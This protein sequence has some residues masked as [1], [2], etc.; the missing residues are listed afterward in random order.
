MQQDATA[1][2]INKINEEI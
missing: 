1:S 2:I